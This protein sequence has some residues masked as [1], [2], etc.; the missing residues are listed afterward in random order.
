MLVVIALVVLLLCLVIGVP[1][2]LAFLA[3]AVSICL[4]GGYDPAMLMMFG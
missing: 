2:P 4:T 1:I 3:S